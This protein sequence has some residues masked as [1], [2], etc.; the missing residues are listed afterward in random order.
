VSQANRVDLSNVVITGD[1]TVVS[2]APIYT[3]NTSDNTTDAI[4][5]L[6][7]TYRPPT[8]SI[9]DVNRDDSECSIHLKNH[10]STTGNTACLIYAPYGPVAI[11]NN[12]VQYG[13]IYAEAIEIKNN[14]TLT[15]DDRIQ[16]VVGFGEVT[17]E[18][19][20]W[21]ELAP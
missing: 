2:N 19:L 21:I 8:G 11:K 10:F 17:Y 3:D 9:C 7:S 13:A 1:T 18:V 14:Q 15:Y 6:V 4:L 20:S 5:T 12:Q 16:H